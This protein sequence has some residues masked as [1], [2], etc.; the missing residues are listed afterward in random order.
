MAGFFDTLFGGGA[1]R[2]AA[3]R[4]RAALAQYQG[5]SLDALKAAYGTGTDAINK[6]IGAYDPLAALGNK[7]NQAGDVWMSALGVTD[8]SKA[9]AAFQTTPGY[10]LTQDAALDAIDRRRAIGGMYASG[11]ADIDTGNWI[12]KNLY[13]TQY[14]PWMQGLQSAAGMGGQYTAGAAQG[15]A[16]GY[17]NLANLAQQ[18]GN[19]QTGVYGNVTSGNIAANNQQAAGEAQGAKNL[20]GAGLSLAGMATGAGAFTGLGTSLGNM[21]GSALA[22]SGGFTGFTNFYRG[23]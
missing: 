1:E 9:A 2:E 23:S 13:E 16:G 10:K 6:S 18:Y 19:N 5:N 12:T 14:Q 15:Q 17:T 21:V 20:L 4:N 22:P 7:Y 8:P 11:N 3:D